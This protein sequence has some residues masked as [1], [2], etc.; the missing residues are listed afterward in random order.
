[1]YRDPIGSNKRKIWSLVIYIATLARGVCY[2]SL[3]E[4]ALYYVVL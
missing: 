4:K 1:M 2:L 3:L